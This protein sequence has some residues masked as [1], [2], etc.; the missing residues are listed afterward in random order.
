MSGQTII[1][2]IAALII[3]IGASFPIYKSIKTD[4]VSKKLSFVRM[5]ANCIPFIDDAL[6]DFL[7]VY[8]SANSPQEA[9]T[10]VVDFLYDIIAKETVLDEKFPG[11]VNKANIEKYVMPLFMKIYI[12]EL[13]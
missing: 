11:I 4:T 9:C 5:F 13:K 8:H 10:T 2:I 1:I 7:T 12:T 3:I 6:E